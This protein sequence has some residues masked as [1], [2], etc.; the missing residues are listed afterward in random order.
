MDPIK[1]CHTGSQLGKTLHAAVRRKNALKKKLRGGT[2]LDPA[3]Q[4]ELNQALCAHAAA[5]KAVH[6]HEAQIKTTKCGCTPGYLSPEE[7][8][9]QIERQAQVIAALRHSQN[10]PEKLEG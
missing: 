6:E 4:Q 9:V 7:L 2:N 1:I 8:N 10:V 5:L 3:E